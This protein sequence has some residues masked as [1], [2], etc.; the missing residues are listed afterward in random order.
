MKALL[1]I[2][3][4][5]LSNGM[6]VTLTNGQEISVGSSRWADLTVGDRTLSG[7]QFQ[8][9]M[10]PKECWLRDLKTSTGTFVNGTRVTATEICDGDVIQSGQTSI[11]VSLISSSVAESN[12]VPSEF[13]VPP[14]LLVQ[15]LSAA[16]PNGLL[17]LSSDHVP[18]R[19]IAIECI[20]AGLG[21]LTGAHGVSSELQIAAEGIVIPDRL[22]HVQNAT[23]SMAIPDDQMWL[24][25]YPEI[26]DECLSKF[27]GESDSIWFVGHATPVTLAWVRSQPR[28]GNPSSINGYELN[29]SSSLWIDTFVG[30]F[31]A[32][33]LKDNCSIPGWSLFT[34]P[35]RDS[36]PDDALHGSSTPQ[37][38][39]RLSSIA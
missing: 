7:L 30:H 39:A 3:G 17:R 4:P 33:L 28:R 12:F 25:V 1:S 34:C 22:S 26:V 38:S 9:S 5:S 29:E 24:T 10:L 27:W 21:I 13:R 8:I 37:K 23:H 32:L 18:I 20:T 6:S 11:T 36:T 2:V 15:C 19:Q 16:F 14:D 31:Q 35:R